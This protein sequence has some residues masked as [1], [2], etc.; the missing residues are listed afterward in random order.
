MNCG[1]FGVSDQADAT[2]CLGDGGGHPLQSLITKAELTMVAKLLG[3][4]AAVG[5]LILAVRPRWAR[6]A[7][8]VAAFLAAGIFLAPIITGREPRG[9]RARVLAMFLIESFLLSAGASA[10]LFLAA[11]PPAAP[12]RLP[13]VGRERRDDVLPLARA[14]S[15]ALLSTPGGIGACAMLENDPSSTISA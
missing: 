3:S 10:L 15:M 9:Q 11:F 8:C 5:L 4:V 13:V 14:F 2:G 1:Q 12:D 7:L 6:A